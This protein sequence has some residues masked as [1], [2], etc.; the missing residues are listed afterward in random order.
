MRYAPQETMETP[1]GLSQNIALRRRLAGRFVLA[2][3]TEIPGRSPG[4]A[5]LQSLA[6]IRSSQAGTELA[7]IICLRHLPGVRDARSI[8]LGAREAR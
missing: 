1:L 7:R 2:W 5:G 8:T 6:M 3:P 4:S